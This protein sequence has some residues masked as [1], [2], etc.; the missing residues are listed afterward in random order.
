M[1]AI[2][3]PAHEPKVMADKNHRHA[4]TLLELCE[5]FDDSCGNRHVESR[6]GFSA[7]KSSGLQAIAIAIA[8]RWRW[9]PDNAP[10]RG[11]AGEVQKLLRPLL[12]PAA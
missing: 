7:I 10:A 2:G 3:D 8:R 6:R 9:P 4:K 5:K 12:G 1:D 11:D